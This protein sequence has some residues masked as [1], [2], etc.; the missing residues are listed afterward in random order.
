MS[1]GK[2]VFQMTG[3]IACYKACDLLSR[4]QKSGYELEVVVTPSALEFVGE[5]T[6]EGLTGKAVHKSVFDAGKHMD[7]I[8]LAR[9]A[10]LMLLCPATANTISK[11]AAGLGDDLISTLF[12]AH[13][14]SKP[15]VIAPAMNA[16]MMDHPAVRAAVEKLRS[17]G[18]DVL[19]SGEGHLACGETGEGRLLEP[20][21]LFALIESR[22]AK[23]ATT[24][25][26]MGA[27]PVPP[28]SEI[29][30]DESPRPV[31]DRRRLDILVTAGGTR[32]PIDR[33]RS[34]ANFSTGRTGAAIAEYF[35][36]LGHRVT[37]VRA[38]DAVPA[39][40][41]LV[42]RTFS[43]FDELKSLLETELISKHYDAVVHAAAVSDFAVEQIVSDGR[44]INKSSTGKPAKIDSDAPTSLLLRRNPKLVDGLRALSKNPAVKIF[45][46]KL[47]DGADDETRNFA[48]KKLAERAKPDF[49]VHNDFANIRGNAHPATV[50]AVREGGGVIERVAS[51]TTRLEIA[52]L[53]GTLL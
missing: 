23:N 21:Q 33:I 28:V 5:A 48:V 8:R 16:A 6:I 43:T 46:L 4:L 25:V 47:T 17:W 27:N 41:N 7:H 14:F 40:T 39:S 45:A 18:V 15:Y 50:Y 13:D 10:D 3:S 35:A 34:I 26:V 24:P 53:L 49:I 32:E 19:P 11:L 31:P 9:W 2:I 52:K 1:N 36:G 20:D 42:E 38:T 44:A 29:P 37:L 30:S 51:A 22:L 12:L